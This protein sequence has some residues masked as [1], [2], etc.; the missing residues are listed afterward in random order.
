M[1]FMNNKT[2]LEKV[3]AEIESKKEEKYEKQLSQ[4]KNQEKK[5]KKMA[6]LEERKKR[7]HRLIERGAILESFI[8]GGLSTHMQG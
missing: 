3:K 6:S 8:E 1:I 4:L 7:T 5:L 2:E